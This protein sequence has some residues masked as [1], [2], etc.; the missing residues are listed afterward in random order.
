M[1]SNSKLEPSQRI[2]FLGEL[3]IEFEWLFRIK[4]CTCYA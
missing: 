3:G 2:S 1:S 4:K